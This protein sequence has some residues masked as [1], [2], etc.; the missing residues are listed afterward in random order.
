QDNQFTPGGGGQPQ[1]WAGLNEQGSLAHNA[2]KMYM[3]PTLDA[4]TYQFAMT[5]SGD[6]DLYVKVGSAPSLTSYDCRP[7][8]TG[9]NETC[10]VTLAQSA[11]IGVMVNGYSSSS[12]F[13]L[14]GSKI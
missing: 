11:P 12:S 5:G 6:A 7:Y 9:T 14:V 1:P 2:K 8:K 13:K 4:G 10:K 3:T